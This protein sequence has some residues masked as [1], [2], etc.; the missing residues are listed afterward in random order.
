MPKKQRVSAALKVLS[1]ENITSWNQKTLPL[2]NVFVVA[3]FNIIRE[4]TNAELWQIPQVCIYQLRRY[5]DLN[6][7]V[8]STVAQPLSATG[9]SSRL[10]TK[11]ESVIRQNVN[12]A[13]RGGMFLDIQDTRILIRT[14][15]LMKRKLSRRFPIV[16]SCP[17]QPIFPSQ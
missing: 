7:N 13:Q 8:A 12:K 17:L 3:A 1:K 15:N 10:N 2:A 14:Q 11:N 5:L 6:G 9:A 4:K 16:Y